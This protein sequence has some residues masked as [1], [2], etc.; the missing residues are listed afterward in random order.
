MLNFKPLQPVLLL[1]A[2]VL[3]PLTFA[4]DTFAWCRSLKSIS[5]QE[6]REAKVPRLTAEQ[7]AQIHRHK[8]GNWTFDLPLEEVWD[9]YTQNPLRMAWNSKLIQYRF[10]LDPVTR[11]KI[12]ESSR[13]KWPGL[14]KGLRFYLDILAEPIESIC[15]MGM[16]VEVTEVKPLESIRYEYL[17]FS[18]AYGTQWIYFERLGPERTRVRHVTEYRGKDF[19]IDKSYLRYHSEAIPAFH[20]SV[21]DLVARGLVGHAHPVRAILGTMGRATE[22]R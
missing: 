16:G 22:A 15:H 8:D 9:I 6:L 10:A 17:D 18:P 1:C 19:I 5:N 11:L 12:D 3:S 2:I 20:R 21:K 7:K 13:E 14:V 4:D